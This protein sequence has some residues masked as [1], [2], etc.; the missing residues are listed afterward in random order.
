MHHICC[1][2]CIIPCFALQS[3]RA[4]YKFTCAER[5]HHEHS[6]RCIGIVLDV[7]I[8]ESLV[9]SPVT[10]NKRLPFVIYETKQMPYL[11]RLGQPDTAKLLS[12]ARILFVAMHQVQVT[13]CIML[14][15]VCLCVCVCVRYRDVQNHCI[16][17]LTCVLPS[18]DVAADFESVTATLILY[19][20][21]FGEGICNACNG[22]K[23]NSPASPSQFV[24]D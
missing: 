4:L 23:S 7:E 6:M 15:F 8:S 18:S 9:F 3:A 17:A 22:H 10:T 14:V 5:R 11:Y 2:F 1:I 19:N 12:S 21:D 13:R 24:M 16:F 20:W